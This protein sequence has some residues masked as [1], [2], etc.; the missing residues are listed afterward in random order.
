MQILGKLISNK[1]RELDAIITKF[2]IQ[3]NNPVSILN[4]DMARNFLSS[5]K[6]ENK[7]SMFKKA[8]LLE[9]AETSL[10]NINI[11]ISDQKEEFE[12][13]ERVRITLYLEFFLP[14]RFY[15]SFLRLRNKMI[16]ICVKWLKNSN[17]WKD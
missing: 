4:Q 12:I 7:Y 17:W 1:K 8:T 6:A 10:S 15:H 14:T 11:I 2:R 9:T 5:N 16:P 3:P 13:K